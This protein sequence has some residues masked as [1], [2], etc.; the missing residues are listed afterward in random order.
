M[1]HSNPHHISKMEYGITEDE[2]RRDPFEL[3]VL[4]GFT[5][6]NHVLLHPGFIIIVSLI[7]IK[8]MCVCV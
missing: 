4:E 8:S 6:V 2:N 1:I 3:T 7:I 5:I